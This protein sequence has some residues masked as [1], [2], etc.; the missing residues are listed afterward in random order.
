MARFGQMTKD[1]L[2]KGPITR[3][4][5][6]EGCHHHVLRNKKRVKTWLYGIDATE[7]GKVLRWEAGHTFKGEKGWTCVLQ[8]CC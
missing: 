3:S 7:K 1:P 2:A 5:A 6:T 4:R 8:C